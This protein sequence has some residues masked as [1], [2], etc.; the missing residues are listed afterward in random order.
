MPVAPWLLVVY[1]LAVA[2]LTGLTVADSITLPIRARILD[3]LDDEPNSLGWWIGE[4]F[5]CPWCVSVWIG[6]GLAPAVWWYGNQPWLVIP[7]IALA[8]SQ[9]AGMTSEWGR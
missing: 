3:W 9:V 7:A 6:A 8:F 4:W 1:A 5:S 2:R